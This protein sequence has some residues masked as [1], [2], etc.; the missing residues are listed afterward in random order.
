MRW[1]L[2]IIASF[3]GAIVACGLWSGLVIGMFGTARELARNS[4]LLFFSAIIPFGL[5]AFAGI[6]VYRHTARRR[7]TQ[8]AVAGALTLILSAGA[9]FVMSQAFPARLNLFHTA[10]I[11]EAH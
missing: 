8:A 11:R 1:K 4:W 6:F 3:A 9:I 7:K 10:A 5:S 2:L